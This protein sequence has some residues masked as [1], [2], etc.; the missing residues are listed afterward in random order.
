MKA[1][2]VLWFTVI[3]LVIAVGML[4]YKANQRRGFG[5]LA[6]GLPAATFIV[7]GKF[8]LK[9]DYLSSAGI[10]L[11]IAASVWNAWPRKGASGEKA[12]QLKPYDESKP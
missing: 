5:P 7:F 11:L 2:Y 1:E 9:E 12:I 10:F 6:I 4:G 3:S 8:Y